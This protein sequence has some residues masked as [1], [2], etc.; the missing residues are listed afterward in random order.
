[1]KNL[2][3]KLLAM[4]MIVTIF[5]TY[6]PAIS[7]IVWAIE[8]VG[9]EYTKEDNGT[10]IV[11]E[12]EDEKNSKE[13]L[14][15]EN[16]DENNSINNEL[17]EK[18]EETNNNEQQNIENAE[19]NSIEQPEKNEHN[20]TRNLK[21]VDQNQEQ[22]EQDNESQDEDTIIE[23]DEKIKSAIISNGYDLNEDGEL[24]IKEL[25]NE[26][27][28]YIDIN[29]NNSTVDLTGI[30]YIV[31]L[32]HINIYSISGTIDV[33]ELVKLANLNEL[34]IQG[35]ITDIDN[36]ENLTKIKYLNLGSYS[37]NTKPNLSEKLE[38][39]TSLENLYIG[40]NF[41]LDTTKLANLTNLKQ[42]SLGGWYTD[43]SLDFSALGTL[44]NLEYL[45]VRYY[46]FQN[47]SGLENLSN[48]KSLEIALQNESSSELDTET[49]TKMTNLQ[50][51][52]IENFD[53]S[54]IQWLAEMSH[55]QSLTLSNYDYSENIDSDFI[56][57]LNSL[58]IETINLSLSVIYNLGEVEADVETEVNFSDIPIVN[59]LSDSSSKLY[60]EDF[61]LHPNENDEPANEISV[62][63]ENKKIYITPE[64]NNRRYDYIN[65]NSGINIKLQWSLASDNEVPELSEKLRQTLINNGFDENN[66]GVLTMSELNSEQHTYLN[67]YFYDDEE[68]DLTGIENLKNLYYLS[69]NSYNKEID[70]SCIES[71]TNLHSLS[72]GGIF[73]TASL[74]KLTGLK[75]LSIHINSNNNSNNIALD[76]LKDLTNLENLSLYGL[77]N[78][79][80][81]PLNNLTNLSRLE[82][83][84]SG[85]GKINLNEISSLTNLYELSISNVDASDLSGI[86]NFELL[87]KLEIEQ[88]TGYIDNID[89]TSIQKLNNLKELRL[90]TSGDLSWVN[91]ITSLTKLT[92][93]GTY[94]ENGIEL[95]QDFIDMLKTI[96]ANVVFSG[97]F[98]YNLGNFEVGSE[99]SKDLN[100]L[101]IL[102]EMTD[103]NSK[104]YSSTINVNNNYYG[105]NENWTYDSE[106]RVL[107][108]KVNEVSD[109]NFGLSINYST[110]TG[111]EY[112][113]LN[114]KWRGYVNGSKNPITIIDD[115]LKQELIDNYDIDDDG[116]IT[117]HDM[118]NISELDLVNK[119]I[120]DV[121]GL[122]YATNARWID[123]S[124]NKISDVTPMLDILTSD[125]CIVY[126]ANN[127]IDSLEGI[128]NIKFENVDLSN[129]YLD[130][131]DGSE[132][133]QLIEEYATNYANE[134][135]EENKDEIEGI[136]K[137]RYIEY[138]KLSIVNSYKMQR[139][140]SVSEREDVLEFE[141]ALYNKL[142]ELGFDTNSDGNIT[143]G[144]LND[145]SFNGEYHYQVD[146]SNI[147]I[148][149]IENLKYLSGINEINL[150]GN[151]IV[152]ISPLK[153]S[154]NLNSINLSNNSLESIEG[155]KDYFNVT[156]LKLANN[157]IKDITPLKYL[158]TAKAL[159]VGGGLGY[160]GGSGMYPTRS[161]NIDLSNNQI[162]DISVLN[163]LISL[164]E[165]NL[166]GNKIKDISALSNYDFETLA[167]GY[168][169]EEDYYEYENVSIDVRNNYIDMEANKNIAAVEH[170]EDYS[171]TIKTEDQNETQY[172][173]GDVNG[174]GTVDMT[175]Y[176][177]ILK[178]VKGIKTLTG[179]QLD[180]A[181]V[182]GNGSVDMTDY[183]MVLKHVKGI[184][185]LN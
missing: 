39:L 179:E 1:M 34:F 75:E 94:G 115:N 33:G 84:Y 48:L 21:A 121:T 161:L 97:Q 146:L 67:I 184:K 108:V 90:Y 99:F 143:K 155:V 114:L 86:E 20:N 144:E 177:M 162:E 5:T 137:E 58:D 128:E 71:L 103:P 81:S 85:V 89:S 91:N 82:I 163:E 152:D 150:S 147:G 176:S 95:T 61:E 124:G 170:F 134:D 131:S 109:Y 10:E 118:I 42:L 159:F 92:L 3:K 122:Q 175:D 27:L 28:T 41:T 120:T 52:S 25:S 141:D 74:K 105:E 166:S 22:N 77:K 79:S 38:T 26:Y 83:N 151:N 111:Y 157:K 80:L 56:N 60:V 69:L 44:T 13:E 2:C 164:Y 136:S 101:P 53:A 172:L 73:N 93:F 65:S 87:N 4:L 145:Y 11:T 135:Y 140:G 182:N 15:S 76:D 160:Y 12:I 37:Y 123:L 54:N 106:N 35:E 129:N 29:C 117:E 47:M 139:Y 185:L 138:Q 45:T 96:N 126:L 154:K 168:E 173:K 149:N 17:T 127:L 119:N 148:T 62:D 50:N 180:R 36:L 116:V 43:E 88:A 125:D 110:N 132:N 112:I 156:T 133:L 167:E 55:L 113:N 6:V 46:H 9:E 169:V 24:S 49:L 57:T 7:T 102:Q 66:D 32:T 153:E 19:M 183:S 107:N 68:I 64:E 142:I 8:E 14:N 158:R 78:E 98:N 63:N 104:F 165:A 59:A 72:L 31:N 100:E 70:L 174:N 130:F 171:S 18:K 51:L 23:L 30:E 16:V 178:H 40:G 181:D